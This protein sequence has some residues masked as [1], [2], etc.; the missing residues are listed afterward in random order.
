[1]RPPSPYVSWKAVWLF[2]RAAWVHTLR[3]NW[4]TPIV[5]AFY[6][7]QLVWVNVMV[8]R[9]IVT[10]CALLL[11]GLFGA[12]LGQTYEDMRRAVMAQANWER[13]QQL[14]RERLIADGMPPAEAD[15]Q[16][17]Q[18]EHEIEQRLRGGE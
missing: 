14:L 12:R 10:L 18:M 1:M 6:V 8:L 9:V 13:A 11:A 15:L 7:V 2:H 4:S 3:R 5:L 17:W 16:L